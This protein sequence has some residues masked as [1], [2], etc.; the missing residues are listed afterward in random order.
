MLVDEGGVVLGSHALEG[1]TQ[2]VVVG[3]EDALLHGKPLHVAHALDAAQDAH[4][5]VA[6]LDGVLLLRLQGHEVAHL[7]VAAETYHLLADGVLEAEDHAHRDEHHGQS[8]GHSGDGYP[9]GR[10]GHLET[11][12]AVGIDASCDIQ[13]QVH[14]AQSSSTLPG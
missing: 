1:H 8:D 9:H 4:H 7:D 12:V 6:H 3:L 13:G 14:K 5:R 2:K 11:L 10:S